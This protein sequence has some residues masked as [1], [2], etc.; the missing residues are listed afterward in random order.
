[1]VRAAGDP[2][3]GF[4]EKLIVIS[5][6][7]FA[8]DNSIDLPASISPEGVADRENGREGGVVFVNGSVMPTISIRAGEVQRWRVIN[9]SA[10]RVYRLTIPGHKLLHVGNDGGLFGARGATKSPCQRRAG[11]ANSFAAPS[12]GDRAGYRPPLGSLHHAERPGMEPNARAARP[13]HSKER[14]AAVRSPRPE[15]H[16]RLTPPSAAR[17]L[18]VLNQGR[19]TL[20]RW[21]RRWMSRSPGRDEIWEIENPS[22]GQPFHLPASRSSARSQR[23]RAV[24]QGRT[25]PT[26][27]TARR[28]HRALREPSGKVD[29]HC[30]SSTTDWDDGDSGGRAAR[31]AGS[32]RNE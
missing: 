6:N 31:A 8:A 22:D 1:M 4:A 9:G 29:V 5:D 13:S 2:L 20:K 18:M 7:R 14:L 19:A 28:G 23:S 12:A 16:P 10:A 3:R 24:P 27:P 17:R 32:E 11:R 21:I 30:T 15:A 26:S 25:S